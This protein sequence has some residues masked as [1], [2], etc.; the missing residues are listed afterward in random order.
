MEFYELLKESLPKGPYSDDDESLVLKELKVISLGFERARANMDALV[1]EFFSATTDARL[2]DWASEY[3]VVSAEGTPDYIRRQSI[4][5]KIR[6]R[7]GA[8]IADIQESLYPFLG[9]LPEINE[10]TLFRT[11]DS[12]SLTDQDELT[13]VEEVYRFEVI[14][15]GSQITT[16]GFDRDVVQAYLGEI[17]PAHTQGDI[18]FTL[19][20]TDD[21]LYSRTDQDELD[22]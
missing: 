22:K 4:Q 18:V 2:A 19:F 20:A 7:P 13:E 14:V 9:Y 16:P 1:E 5:A 12:G 17:K 3:G 15:D 21:P 8:S 10:Q 6:A 11:D